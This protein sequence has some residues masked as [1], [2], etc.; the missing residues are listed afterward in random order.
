MTQY[1]PQLRIRHP[2]VCY[3]L[4]WTTTGYTGQDWRRYVATFLETPLLL[5]IYAIRYSTQDETNY[6][7]SLRNTFF[8]QNFSVAI[9]ESF[10]YGC[11]LALAHHLDI[12]VVTYYPFPRWEQDGF[13]EL[14]IM[15]VLYQIQHFQNNARG[16]VSVR[17]ISEVRGRAGFW[18]GLAHLPRPTPGILPLLQAR[19]HVRGLEH[20]GCNSIDKWDLGRDL[21]TGFGTSLEATSVRSWDLGNKKFT[22]WPKWT[23][24]TSR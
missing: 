5:S 14:G 10:G 18:Q 16:R 15:P 7:Q 23:K 20:Q 12:P 1:C 9:L 19:Q 6:L 3:F 8:V 2:Q 17:K 24:K 13:I 21:R 4:R 22:G 11:Y